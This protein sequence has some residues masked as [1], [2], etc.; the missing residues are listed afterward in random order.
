MRIR[1]IGLFVTLMLA[2]TLAACAPDDGQCHIATVGDLKVLN[3]TGS[4]IVA[5]TLNDKPVAFIIDTGGEV[6]MLTNDAV[7]TYGLEQTGRFMPLSGVGGDALF[8][9]AIADRLGLGSATASRAA[10][11]T[12]LPFHRKIG[13]L[14][15]AGILGTDV[16]MNY[17]IVM[18]LPA[19]R[20]NLYRTSG[21]TRDNLPLWPGQTYMMPF[22]TTGQ[23]YVN[24]LIKIAL[25][26]HPDKALLDSGAGRTLITRSSALAAGVSASELAAE[27]K[28]SVLGIDD[29]KLTTSRHV[30][31]Q[32]QVGPFTLYDEPASVTET[33]HS[34]I[35]APFLWTHRVW[36]ATREHMIY[37]QPV[38][39][40]TETH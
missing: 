34:L 10:F 28:S 7:S 23:N 32:L 1:H 17:D 18:D 2:T 15:I 14:P 4:P 27:P 37:V 25:N 13:N 38:R 3:N 40:V 35:G 24:L 6:S 5:A 9:V 11:V 20:I 19:H 12:N 21:C 36:V 33:D 26:G 8:G 22:S 30:F 39:T 31:K 29:R 16:L